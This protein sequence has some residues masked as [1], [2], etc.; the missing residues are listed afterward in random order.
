MPVMN[1]DGQEVEVMN[2]GFMKYADTDITVRIR[3]VRRHVKRG[4]ECPEL[5]QKLHDTL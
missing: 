4:I 1:G 2:S 3:H 5:P